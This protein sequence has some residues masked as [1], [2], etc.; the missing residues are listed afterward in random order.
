[1][2]LCVT[3][4]RRGRRLWGW[5]QAEPWLDDGGQNHGGLWEDVEKGLR[6]ESGG[7]RQRC[8]HFFL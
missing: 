6:T 3:A 4:G 8:E 7:W 1:M 2:R 5:G